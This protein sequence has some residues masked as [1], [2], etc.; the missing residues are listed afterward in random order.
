[1]SVYGG[2]IFE[3]NVYK[4]TIVRHIDADTTVVDIDPGFDLTIRKTVRWA[5]INA[6]EKNTPEGKEA[7]AFVMEAMPVGSA[8]MLISTKSTRDKYGRYLASFFL[9]GDYVDFGQRLIERGW[10][11]PYVG[12]Q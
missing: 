4:A 1:M 7:L 12:R 11:T 2:N 9:E 3:E 5:G 8:V 10:A 6:A